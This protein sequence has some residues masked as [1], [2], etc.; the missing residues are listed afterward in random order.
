MAMA[1]NRTLQLLNVTTIPTTKA[2][3]SLEALTGGMLTIVHHTTIASVPTTI[4]RLGVEVEE[5]CVDEEVKD[6]ELWVAVGTTRVGLV[7][8]TRWAWAWANN[9]C[10]LICRW[11]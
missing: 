8:E 5:V 3:W 4:Y 9:R 1:I 7:G 11:V 2:R 10:M 6:M